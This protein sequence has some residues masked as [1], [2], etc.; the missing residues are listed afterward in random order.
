VVISPSLSP[1]GIRTGIRFGLPNGVGS[2]DPTPGGDQV[3]SGWA[4]SEGWG[5]CPNP[6]RLQAEGHWGL[7]DKVPLAGQQGQTPNTPG[8]WDPLGQ[9]I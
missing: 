9:Q 4:S 5:L 6:E 1:P 8:P 3:S 7:L 2:L